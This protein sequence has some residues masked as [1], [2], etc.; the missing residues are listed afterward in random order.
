MRSHQPVY[1]TN[2]HTETRFFTTQITTYKPVY[3][4]NYHTSTRTITC[5]AGAEDPGIVGRGVKQQLPGNRDRAL[6]TKFTTQMETGNEIYYANAF[7][8]LVIRNCAVF[9]VARF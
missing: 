8:L 2:Y 7:I 3:Y 5:G 1:Y 6:L 4:T 9:V